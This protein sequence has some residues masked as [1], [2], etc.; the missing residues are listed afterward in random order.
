MVIDDIK[1]TK[2]RCMAFA[3]GDICP[4]P[5]PPAAAH[6]QSQPNRLT[7]AECATFSSLFFPI[8]ALSSSALAPVH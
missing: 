8:R 3:V 1:E 6:H 7:A 2:E 4:A 5:A